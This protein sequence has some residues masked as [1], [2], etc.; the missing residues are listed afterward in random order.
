MGKHVKV[1]QHVLVKGQDGEEATV[2]WHKYNGLMSRINL[3]GLGHQ[4]PP[5]IGVSQIDI[6]EDG[7]HVVIKAT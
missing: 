6:H 1:E 4:V 3:F 7:Q 5:P 2:L